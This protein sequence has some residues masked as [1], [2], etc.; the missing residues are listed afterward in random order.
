M[1]CIVKPCTIQTV[2]VYCTRTSVFTCTYEREMRK[3]EEGS[4]GES[5][6][7]PILLAD[8]REAMGAPRPRA[9][10]RRAR[11]ARRWRATKVAGQ[12]RA[13]T[14]TRTTLAS[15]PRSPD[16]IIVGL[17]YVVAFVDLYILFCPR[18]LDTRL[19]D[20]RLLD[21]RLSDP[22]LLYPRLLDPRLVEEGRID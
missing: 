7:K 4:E 9:R 15:R 16:S 3:E 20:P 6:K 5:R 19:L 2:Y 1:A 12:K 13:P 10:A 11:R 18:R 21:P 8:A 22:R 17:P 14:P